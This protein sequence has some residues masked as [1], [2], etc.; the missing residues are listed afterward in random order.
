VQ[1]N[2][3]SQ[4]SGVEWLEDVFEGAK[5]SVKLSDVYSQLFFEPEPE[6]R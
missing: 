4:E 2:R 5:V 1:V 6:P 3:E